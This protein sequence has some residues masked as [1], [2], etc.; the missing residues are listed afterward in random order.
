[1]QAGDR[2][3]TARRPRADN[4]VEARTG[5]RQIACV[6]RL[7]RHAVGAEA[8]RGYLQH[9]CFTSGATI[10]ACGTARW[11]ARV[12]MPVPGADRVA[13]DWSSG[14]VRNRERSTKPGG[15]PPNDRL[16]LASRTPLF[17]PCVC[18]L[19]GH[20]R[21]CRRRVTATSPCDWAYRQPRVGAGAPAWARHTSTNVSL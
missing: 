15:V 4:E 9:H 5:E 1:M 18:W 21:S 11:S 17:Q 7:E 20:R 13:A 19:S 2:Q 8:L 16:Y 6:R 10:C 14:H 12:T 3:E